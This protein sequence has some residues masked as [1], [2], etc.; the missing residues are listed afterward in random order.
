[1]LAIF[2]ASVFVRALVEREPR[3]EKWI[4]RAFGDVEVGVPNLLFAEV[5]NALAGY[6]RS[7]VLSARA[8]D[9]RLEFTLR[10]PHAVTDVGELAPAALAVA[11]ARGLSVYDG[12]YV[13][14]AEG[15]DA[16]LVTADRRL[17]AVV[18]RA[19]LL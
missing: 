17:A 11:V 13:V 3:A 6:V 7:G 16:P 18:K 8:A 1:L 2:D 19:E 14:L 4:D 5:G 15:H 10:L 9:A 12:C